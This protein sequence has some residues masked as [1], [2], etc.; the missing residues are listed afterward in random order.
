MATIHC[1][2]F[3]FA[4][5]R[6][7]ALTSFTRL[8][9]R[10]T[11]QSRVRHWGLTRRREIVATWHRSASTSPAIV[12]RHRRWGAKRKANTIGAKACRMGREQFA[13]VL[14]KNDLTSRGTLNTIMADSFPGCGRPS[15]R[16]VG[17]GTIQ[18]TESFCLS[19][20]HLHHDSTAFM[21]KKRNGIAPTYISPGTDF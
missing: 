21:A 11:Y 3:P 4:C 2:R 19:Q 7:Q 13:V 17:C 8:S 18:D 10:P 15:C 5:R 14:E 9:Y 12:F 16:P 20:H 1:R 6:S